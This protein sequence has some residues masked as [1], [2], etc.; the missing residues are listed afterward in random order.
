[1]T[2]HNADC[3]EVLAEMDAESVDAVITDPP[4]GIGFMGHEWDKPALDK[5]REERSERPQDGNRFIGHV[6]KSDNLQFQ[7]WCQAWATECLRVLKP[8]GYMA[9]FGATRLYHRLAV[10]IEDAGF[11]I[12]DSLAWLYGSG[13]PKSRNDGPRGTALKPAWEPIV[14][15]QK[16]KDGTYAN[17]YEQHGTGYL[18]IDDARV[19]LPDGD[20]DAGGRWPANVAT[21]GSEAVVDALPYLRGPTNAE[22]TDRK[23]YDGPSVGYNKKGTTSR[24]FIDEGSATRFFYTGKPSPSEKNAGLP[25]KMPHPTIKPIELMRWIIRLL[26]P[27][28]GIVLDP[29]LGSGTTAIAAILEGRQW[30][31]VEREKEYVNIAETRIAWWSAQPRGRSVK[32]ILSMYRKSSDKADGLFSKAG[33]VA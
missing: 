19:P 12:R 33:E 13:F 5:R 22:S 27:S 31:G 14:V 30:I 26:A 16:P 9:A 25:A 29:F 21:D 11:D 23:D 3:L 4:Y 32:K 18:N 15:A 20:K 6:P 8:G 17:N 24:H 10:S 2:I 1:M 28:K 7:H